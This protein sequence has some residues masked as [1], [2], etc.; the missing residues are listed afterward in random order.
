MKKKVLLICCILFCCFFSMNTLASVRSVTKPEALRL[1]QERFE[2]KDVDYYILNNYNSV[3]NWTIFVD[4]E[5]M[6]GWEHDCYVL[7]IPRSVKDNSVINV[8]I[9][10]RQI[11]PKGNYVPLLVKNRYGS[12]ANEKPHI[13][14]NTSSNGED[15]AAKRTY[16]IILSGGVDQFSNYERYWNDC[17]FIYQTLV[18]KYN[19]PKD[20]IYPIMSD[21]ADPGIDLHS[22]TFISQPLDLDYDG[23]QD[24]YLAATKQNISQ[25]LSSLESKMQKDDQLFIFVIDHGGTD[26]RDSRSYICLWNYES[27]YDYELANMLTPFV[28]KYINVNVVLGQCFSGG[29]NDNLTK[30]GC[31]VASASTGSESSYACSDRPFDEFV[32][33]WTS[34]VNGATHNNTS[35]NADVDHNGKVTMEE[36]FAFAKQ[37]DRRYE[38]P[39]YVSTPISVGEDLAFNHLAPSVDIYIKDNDEDTG[40]EPNLST[41]EFWKSPSIWVRNQDDKICEHQNPEYSQSHQQSFIYVRVHNR[42]KETFH[43]E[44]KW[45]IV[46]WTQA[47]TGINSRAWKGRE[48]YEGRYPT[49]GILEATPIDSI[50]PGKYA[51]VMVRWSLPKLL[52][53]YPEGNFHFCLY[54]KIMDTPYDDGFVEGKAYFDKQG[55]NNQ[56]QKNVTIIRKED[57]SKAFNVYVRNVSSETRPYRLELIPQTPEDEAIFSVADVEMGMSPKI[58]N[59]WERGG[60]L[61]QDVELINQNTNSTSD[62][63]RVKL[64]SSQNELRSVNLNSKEFDIVSLKFRFKE[65]MISDRDYT[66]DLIQRDENGNIIDG[67]TF[68]VR[69]PKLLPHK[70]IDIE[71][72]P[73]NGGKFELAVVDTT[74]YINIDWEDKNGEKIG[75]SNSITVL[76]KRDNNQYRVIAT[77]V[78]GDVATGAIT[79]ETVHGIKNITTASSLKSLSVELNNDAPQNSTLSVVSAQNGTIR[80]AEDIQPGT[81][82]ISI[83]TSGIQSG[84]YIVT[85]HINGE[86]IDQK[87]II[88]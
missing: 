80:L 23:I 60:L 52:S 64:L 69:P 34:A 56:A 57:L 29:F 66:L 81:K 75:S 82:N 62:K 51:D 24:I 47:S 22:T 54:A 36:A 53:E 8:N 88:L 41:D 3:Q 50:K 73:I 86:V 65:Y 16:A 83:D 9:N 48:L 72:I 87:K 85:Y 4:A 37:H 11:P 58:Y 33:W 61:C 31:V 63:K 42:G 1:A 67:E 77:T 2:G 35:V 21:G 19:V 74:G 79:I 15:V 25:T 26:D 43:G 45:V 10:K 44:G 40:K 14:K 68:V 30:V 32:Y 12:H 84:L 7:T 17:S 6:K 28:N 78:N 5:P 39:Q 70:P 71:P 49:G 59:A 55:S 38:S 27:L 18:N 46:Y 76:P 20:N 13:A